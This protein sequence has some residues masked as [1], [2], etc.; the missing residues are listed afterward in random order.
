MKILNEDP[1]LDR[2]NLHPSMWAADGRHV[3]GVVA[4]VPAA[5]CRS[6]SGKK[7]CAAAIEIVL[8]RAEIGQHGRDPPRCRRLAP[9]TARRR[10]GVDAGVGVSVDEAGKAEPPPRVEDLPG[11]RGGNLGPDDR[12]APVLH[13]EIHRLDRGLP[14]SHQPHVL[15]D[16][17]EGIGRHVSTISMGKSS[18]GSSTTTRW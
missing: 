5:D 6:T 8:A 12:E 4:P 1:V 18:R 3:I 14:R 10:G 17:V 11:I 7:S 15:D 2:E 9:V 16:E 13:A